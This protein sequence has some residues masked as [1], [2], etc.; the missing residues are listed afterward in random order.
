MEPSFH[1]GNVPVFECRRPDLSK[2][3]GEKKSLGHLHMTMNGI[4][5][6]EEGKPVGMIFV[7]LANTVIL[8]IGGKRYHI[9]GQDLWALVRQGVEQSTTAAT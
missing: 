3:S 5:V 2:E 1:I 4:E 9:R 8:E 6:R 7:D